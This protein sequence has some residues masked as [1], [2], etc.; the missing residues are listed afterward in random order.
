MFGNFLGYCEEWH[1]V[2]KM[3]WLHLGRLLKKCGLLLLQ[4]LVT[5]SVWF[6]NNRIL[7]LKPIIDNSKKHLPN[8]NC[9]NAKKTEKR[10]EMVH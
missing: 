1:F 7:V 5:L 8:V 10:L 3:L 9:Y 2:S 4:H 6:L